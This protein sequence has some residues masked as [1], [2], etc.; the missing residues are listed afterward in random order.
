[1]AAA[2]MIILQMKY[3]C[4]AII[5]SQAFCGVIQSTHCLVYH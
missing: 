4:D 2:M 5:L 3:W 1:M